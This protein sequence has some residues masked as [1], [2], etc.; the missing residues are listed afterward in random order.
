MR[1]G[2]PSL[3]WEGRAPIDPDAEVNLRARLEPLRP[4]FHSPFNFGDGLGPT[5]SRIDQSGGLI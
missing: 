3:G 2:H 1:D 4:F 5:P